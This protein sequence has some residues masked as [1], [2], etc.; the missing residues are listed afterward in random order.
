MMLHVCNT[1][2]SSRI[3]LNELQS[4]SMTDGSEEHLKS[5]QVVDVDTAM[6]P[7][8]PSAHCSC[9]CLIYVVN[10]A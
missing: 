2:Y 3:E 6:Q 9:P 5:H 1:N 7:T 10:S 4:L 8:I